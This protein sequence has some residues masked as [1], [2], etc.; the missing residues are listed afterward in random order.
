MMDILLYKALEFGWDEILM[1]CM[2]FA[3]VAVV[4]ADYRRD[5]DILHTILEIQHKLGSLESNSDDSLA[6]EVRFS[7][8]EAKV[9][10]TE[11]HEER[12]SN[13]QE[14]VGKMETRLD[15]WDEEEDEDYDDDPK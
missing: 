4:Y 9:N 14:R 6:L 1:I 3:A 13:L 10:L 7:E 2:G 12:F 5:R 15:Q 11:R 8:L